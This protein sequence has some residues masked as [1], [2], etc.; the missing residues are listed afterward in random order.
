MH[1]AAAD[2]KH[3]LM[4]ADGTGSAELC[5]NIHKSESSRGTH[6]VSL[7]LSYYYHVVIISFKLCIPHRL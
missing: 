3:D 7:I 5:A 4:E 6:Y 2:R 1:T